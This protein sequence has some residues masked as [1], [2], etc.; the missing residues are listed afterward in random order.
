M[1]F[2]EVDKLFMSCIDK[3]SRSTT[4]WKKLSGLLDKS[5]FGLART[6]LPRGNEKYSRESKSP[7]DLAG[8]NGGKGGQYPSVLFPRGLVDWISSTE[9]ARAPPMSPPLPAAITNTTITAQRNHNP[10]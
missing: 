5:T 3:Q 4:S 2:Y 7:I 1:L 9:S 8:N 6:L 10:P